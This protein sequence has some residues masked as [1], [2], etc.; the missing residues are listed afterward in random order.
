M[1]FKKKNLV[2]D[3]NLPFCDH[4]APTVEVKLAWLNAIR[5]I[6][7]NQQKLFKGE[8]KHLALKTICFYFFYIKK[9]FL[10]NSPTM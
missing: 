4:K 8:Y 10:M 9:I 6:L 2:H 5:K 1:S 3:Y 7:T